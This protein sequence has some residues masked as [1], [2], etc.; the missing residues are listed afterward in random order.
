VQPRNFRVPVRAMTIVN[1][2]SQGNRIELDRSSDGFFTKSP[3]IQLQGTLTVEVV[4]VDGQTITDRIS[5]DSVISSSPFRGGNNVQFSGSSDQTYASASM[6][7]SG[8]PDYSTDFAPASSAYRV[9]SDDLQVVSNELFTVQWTMEAVDK[10]TTVEGLTLKASGG[11]I[12]LGFRY[13][14]TGASRTDDRIEWRFYMDGANAN[15]QWCRVR[16]GTDYCTDKGTRSFP[17]AEG[18]DIT[19]SQSFDDDTSRITSVIQ[20]TTANGKQSLAGRV[21]ESQ[22]PVLGHMGFAFYQASGA[23]ISDLRLATTSTFTVS[24]SECL[25][26]ATW[27]DLFYELVPGVDPAT[28][29]VA[30]IGEPAECG[31]A[32]A[33]VSGLTFAVTS[34]SST[35]PAVANSFTAASNGAAGA[36]AGINSASVVGGTAGA[37]A[38][39]I[40]A[41]GAAAGGGGGAAGGLSGGAIAGIVLGSVAGGILLVGVTGIVVG[42]V[43]LGAVVVARSGDDESSPE[44][45][46]Q[47]RSWRQSIRGFFGGVD[48]MNNPSSGHQSITARSPPT[49]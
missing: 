36:A 3:G 48:V 20:W 30:F 27:T 46:G 8:L 21:P 10:Y 31:G 13:G 1:Y 19:L 34:M 42:A 26:D 29:A 14:Q 28:T 18:L 41:A 32:K 44:S 16:Q 49:R 23:V 9:S 38:A 15:V 25:D 22:F 40:P 24:L 12:G 37:S 33:L 39:G 35:A 7:A 6:S 5:V 11:V 45:S 47:R 17:T 2:P 43:V 4:S